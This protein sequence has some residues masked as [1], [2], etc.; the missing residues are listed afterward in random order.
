M[1][2]FSLGDVP[3]KGEQTMV[4]QKGNHRAKGSG[5]DYPKESEGTQNLV[6]PVVAVP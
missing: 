2:M 5:M 1:G 3:M 6:A 4:K